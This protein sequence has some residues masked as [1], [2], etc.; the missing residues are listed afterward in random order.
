V[1]ISVSAVIQE[2]E[3]SVEISVSAVI[4]TG[5]SGDICT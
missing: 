3:A 2:T 5:V 4:E 1:E